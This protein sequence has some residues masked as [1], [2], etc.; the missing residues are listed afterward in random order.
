MKRKTFVPA[1]LMA[2]DSDPC[3]ERVGETMEYD[4]GLPDPKEELMPKCQCD[5][6]MGEG[7]PIC[8]EEGYPR[9]NP[10]IDLP[11]GMHTEEIIR[12]VQILSHRVDEF[13]NKL[14][15]LDEA[16]DVWQYMDVV[17]WFRLNTK[18]IP[19]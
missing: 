5:E 6:R 4:D 17:G 19:R 7:C 12:F 3:W 1:P 13:T 15:A 2:H 14:V 9:P 11:E 10:E 8:K 16:G 18:R